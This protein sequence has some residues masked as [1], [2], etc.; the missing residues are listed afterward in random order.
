MEHL[1]P[2]FTENQKLIIQKRLEGRTY[3][4]IQQFMNIHTGLNTT[5]KHI[6]KCLLRSSLGL[7]WNYGDYKGD[8]PYL[9]PADLERLKEEVRLAAESGHS[10]ETDEVLDEA[11]RI[12]TERLLTAINFLTQLKCPYLTD[13]I[14]DKSVVPPT[15]QW[16]NGI[17][18]NL[19]SFI[20]NKRLVDSKRLEACSY[21]LIRQ[22]FTKFGHRIANTPPAL[23]FNADETMIE[24]KNKRKVVVPNDVRLVIEAGMPILPHISAMVCSNVFGQGPP[25]LVILEGLKNIPNELKPFAEA[26]V[27]SIG[28]TPSGFMTRDLFLLWIILFINWL[29]EYRMK[30]PLYLQQEKA[31]LILDGHTSRECPLAMVLL[32]KAFVDVL[33]LPSHST[34]VLQW[35]DVGIAAVL[36]QTYATRIKKNLKQAA[37]DTSI[38]SNLAKFRYAVVKSFIDALTACLTISNCTSA[39]KQTGFY[40]YDPRAPEQS[41]FVRNL[42]QEEQDRLVARQERNANRF[43]ISSNIITEAE[44]LVQLDQYVRLSP[45]FQH[46]CNLT[47]FITKTY[48]ELVLEIVTNHHND[49][50]LLSAVTPLFLPGRAPYFFNT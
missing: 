49:S 3:L 26:G 8:Y 18:E 41:P 32:R 47:R 15:R 27:I 33:V 34:H 23:L 12:K 10:M 42:T 24:S 1:L 5:P 37:A 19:E 17:L 46:L 21:D 38:T 31:L 7:Q 9:C 30:L 40:P 45:K 6:S 48:K 35:F 13:K 2:Y 39:A 16:I 22:F 50:L 36:K 14:T 25:P 44:F 11:A 43:T 29:M 4:E 28:S 20:R